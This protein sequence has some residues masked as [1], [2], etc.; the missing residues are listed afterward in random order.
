M[1]VVWSSKPSSCM[2]ATTLLLAAFF[3]CT[4]LS[5]E[6][7]PAHYSTPH[8]A[9]EYAAWMA[10]KEGKPP[11]VTVHPIGITLF[12]IMGQCVQ[13]KNGSSYC[14]CRQHF[15]GLTCSVYKGKCTSET[16]CSP[17]LCKDNPSKISLYECVCKPG[18]HVPDSPAFSHCIPDNL[19]GSA[20]RERDS[21]KTAKRHSAEKNSHLN[22]SVSNTT[23]STISVFHKE[24]KAPQ[25]SVVCKTSDF[26]TSFSEPKEGRDS[27]F[28]QTSPRTDSKMIRAL[29]ARTEETKTSSSSA[30]HDIENQQGS[31]PNKDKSKNN[32][33][34]R[35]Q[36]RSVMK[37]YMSLSNASIT[38]QH[39]GREM[40]PLTPQHYSKQAVN[41][42]MPTIR[43]RRASTFQ[44]EQGQA[45]ENQ[46]I[47][48][49]LTSYSARSK[50][51]NAGKKKN[52]K[53][54][55]IFNSEHN[56]PVFGHASDKGRN[57][58]HIT[59]STE[60]ALEVPQREYQKEGDEDYEVSQFKKKLLNMA[61]AQL[62]SSEGHIDNSLQGPA[63][64]LVAAGMK[65]VL[66]GKKDVKHK[67]LPAEAQDEI[68]DSLK[69][70]VEAS[71][72][73][74]TNETESD[75]E[76]KKGNILVV[77]DK[78]KRRKSSVIQSDYVAE[79]N[80]TNQRLP[81]LIAEPLL[82]TKNRKDIP[83]PT[84]LHRVIQALM[85]HSSEESHLQGATY[86]HDENYGTKMK[87]L[88]NS[89]MPAMTWRK[90]LPPR[91]GDEM[92]PSTSDTSSKKP[93]KLKKFKSSDNAN[94]KSEWMNQNPW[95]EV[96]NQ[97]LHSSK[98]CV[99]TNCD[100]S[101]ILMSHVN[102]Q[103]FNTTNHPFSKQSTWEAIKNTTNFSY[104]KHMSPA[105]DISKS[106]APESSSEAY[107]KR[108]KTK[109]RRSFGRDPKLFFNV[110]VLRSGGRNKSASYLVPFAG[111]KAILISWGTY[112][113][114][115]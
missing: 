1:G 76:M 32:A 5:F 50:N 39:I 38:S 17:H 110:T 10:L 62:A 16:L 58:E 26:R 67:Q 79:D 11:C 7:D 18:Y 69:Y 83:V 91:K 14:Q 20:T 99:S 36:A 106:E 61:P 52:S 64:Y 112:N 107:A 49:D 73:S 65:R 55:S 47:L 45:P 51:E 89:A 35:M 66:G 94:S 101:L 72:N 57:H 71:E 60:V 40:P 13:D 41:V 19:L 102:Y 2:H 12:C 31:L 86:R 33:K 105:R 24:E 59:S 54:I 78:R 96:Q 92:T 88:K 28:G 115:L 87:H 48:D 68:I 3:C 4:V 80:G 77:A 29:T 56:M 108:K 42:Q 104:M 95:S 85:Q 21:T 63:A 98:D 25:P 8:E 44:R 46:L 84:E 109:H 93:K 97:A 9:I 53:L 100:N 90:D 70:A 15:A 30:L 37:P 111:S 23:T 6:P 103:A 113:D 82:A 74:K 75:S 81:F 22:F 43:R 27:F 34:V 114:S